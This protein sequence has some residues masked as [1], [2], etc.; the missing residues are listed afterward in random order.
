[1]RVTTREHRTKKSVEDNQLSNSEALCSLAMLKV[2][3][4]SGGDYM[5]Y[6][7]PYI[8]DVLANDPP[9]KI[10]DMAV[11]EKLSDSC[12]L[13]I[14]PRTVQVVLQRL[15]REGLLVKR[16]GLFTCN[17]S[18]P[19]SDL[20]AARADANRHISL[21]VNELIG[22][23]IGTIGRVLSE[24]E[25]TESLVN[26]LSHFSIP[27]L[28]S[29]LRGTTL[30]DIG[31]NANWQ[32]ALVGHFVEALQSQPNLFDSFTMLMQG[33][34]LANALLCPDLHSVSDT[35][36]DVTFYLDT[37]LLIQLLGLEGERE[38]QAIKEVISLVQRL[39]G[40][41]RYFSHTYD[42]L[43]YSINSSADF[44][45]SYKGRGTIVNEA[46]KSG[47]QKADLL[48]IAGKA[49]E[50]LER[51][52]VLAVSTPSYSEENHKFEIA[53]E[54]FD[55][56]LSDE[57]DY[58][59]PRAKDYDIRSVRSVYVLRRDSSPRSLE[60]A[61]AV[62][63]TSN[64]SFSKAAF[65]YG[66]SFQMSREVSS[67]ITD[68]SLANTA[69][70]KAPQG[71]PALPKKEVL[72][73]AYAAARPP[74]GFWDKVLIEAEKLEKEGKISARDH[75]LLRSSHNVQ[76][77]LT[78][79][80]L[81]DEAAL[82]DEK[83]TETIARVSDDIRKEA[84]EDKNAISEELNVANSRIGALSGDLEAV[85]KNT[86]WDCK[87][88]ADREATALSVAVWVGQGA[89]AA[90]GLFKID[91]ASLGWVIF[92]V[93]LSSGVL[94][95]AGAKWDIKPVN[96]KPRYAEWRFQKLHRKALEKLGLE[97]ESKP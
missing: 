1:M 11:A 9:S 10:N 94:R 65:E 62:L 35:Y 39:N 55:A 34:M 90:L 70:L 22:F 87:R 66:K 81:G 41:V 80:T 54:A 27:C 77:E 44:I 40:K 91:E 72:A 16:D 25:A 48:M 36:N 85:R 43:T 60:K 2:R 69:W 26:F 20:T 15:A 45:D 97:V 49:D 46:R 86:Y 47:M 51:S 8:I 57:I 76:I 58:N 50:I 6:V 73:F 68:F 7:R 14:P 5:D 53:V 95:I 74:R 82:T 37:P 17:D 23:S 42:E 92:A 61:K 28:K 29:Y 88:Q 3:I 52:G 24:D 21:I 93:A 83:I 79:L 30:P 67:V 78:R 75:Q 13:K 19:E 89:V 4:N 12:G 59:N 31:R 96:L 18:F 32:L 71:A 84:L 38:E 56:V 33:H 63:V 64:T